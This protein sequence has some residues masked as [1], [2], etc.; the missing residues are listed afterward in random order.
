ME[1]FT[2]T[3]PSMHRF[4]FPKA[5]SLEA[6]TEAVHDVFRAAVFC[7][8]RLYFP[9]DKLFH[10]PGQK[11]PSLQTF[12]LPSRPCSLAGLHALNMLTTYYLA[13]AGGTMPFIRRYSTIW[14]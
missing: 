8:V 1:R 3:V 10:I 11:A 7:F 4:P 5:R 12:E 9:K 2:S 6:I 14:P 13:L